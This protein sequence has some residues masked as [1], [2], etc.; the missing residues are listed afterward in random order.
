MILNIA[1]YRFV[2]VADPHR[3]ASDVRQHAESLDLRGTVLVAE[4]GKGDPSEETPTVSAESLVFKE[5]IERLSELTLVLLL[6]GMVSLQNW[7]WQTVATAV[8]LFVVARPLAVM[9]GLSFSDTSMR[10]RSIIGWFGVR[11]IG[12]IYYL[13]FAINHGL[14]PKYAQDLIQLTIVV[15]MLSI[16]VHGTSVTPVMDKFWP[17]RKRE[18]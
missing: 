15:V 6:G 2:A 18:S 1:A 16:I 4:E 10:V 14:P 9:I 17:K 12:S 5:H 3:L 11:G 13:M 7:N 8:F